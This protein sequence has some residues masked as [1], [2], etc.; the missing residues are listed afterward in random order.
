MLVVRGGGSRGAASAEAAEAA[1]AAAASSI[2]SDSGCEPSVRDGRRFSFIGR[3][4]KG[5]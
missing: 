4:S 3:E 5:L 1:E 2:S